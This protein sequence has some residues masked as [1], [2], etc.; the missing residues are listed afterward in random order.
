MLYFYLMPLLLARLCACQP[1]CLRFASVG[2]TGGSWQLLRLLWSKGLCVVQRFMIGPVKGPQ[3]LQEPARLLHLALPA[4]ANGWHGCQGC[5]ELSAHPPITPAPPI[6]CS[7][8]HNIPHC[9]SLL[10]LIHLFRLPCLGCCSCVLPHPR[11]CPSH[12]CHCLLTPFLCCCFCHCPQ[13]HSSTCPCPTTAPPDSTGHW[14]WQ[15]AGAD[16]H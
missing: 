11:H 14:C 16:H 6:I 9:L 4:V 3:E 7:S 8:Q 15:Q 5:S 10:C 1:V 2:A 12:P 13:S